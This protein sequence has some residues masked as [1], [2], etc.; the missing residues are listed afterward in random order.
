M[1][2]ERD[3]SPRSTG[4]FAWYVNVQNNIQ[5]QEIL[6]DEAFLS[7][8][9]PVTVVRVSHANGQPLLGGDAHLLR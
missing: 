2:A 4:I 8:S 1:A 6:G 7:G 3:K 9:S 5:S